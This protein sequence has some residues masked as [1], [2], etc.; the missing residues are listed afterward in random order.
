MPPAARAQYARSMRPIEGNPFWS[1]ASMSR[2]E[3][4]L[5][6][7]ALLALISLG[8]VWPLDSVPVR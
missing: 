4:I 2:H 8:I 1:L 6:T 5:N 7:L 3:L